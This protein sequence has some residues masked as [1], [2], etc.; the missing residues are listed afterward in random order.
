MIPVRYQ[1]ELTDGKRR[2][3]HVVTVFSFVAAKAAAEKRAAL[4][5]REWSVATIEEIPEAA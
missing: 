4:L 2:R 1:I 3:G 5:G